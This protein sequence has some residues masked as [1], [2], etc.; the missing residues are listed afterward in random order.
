MSLRVRREGGLSHTSQP[1]LVT[2]KQSHKA[3][4]SKI[5]QPLQFPLVVLLSFTTSSLLSSLL[6]PFFG[7][8]SLRRVTKTPSGWELGALLVWRIFELAVGWYGNYDRWD[9]AA[10]GV[11]S[12][13]PPLYLLGTFYDVNFGELS[14]SLILNILG[15]Y[16]PFGLLRPL[17]SAHRA[18]DELPPGKADVSSD[19][20]IQAITTLL[21]ASIYSVSLYGAYATYLPVNLVSYFPNLTSIVAAHTATPITLLPK[22]LAFG[23]AAKTF[24]FTPATSLDTRSPPFNPVKATFA[25]T[26]W[27]NVWGFSEATRMVLKRTAALA[28]ITGGNTFL[29]TFVALEDVEFLGAVG[30]SAVWFGA[31]G[32]TGLALGIVNAV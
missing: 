1:V 23:I 9:I 20:I 31:A 16:I 2:Q 17:S 18:G 30:Y 4:V 21:G 3:R 15:T 8:E 5:P 26:F 25:E 28:V 24:I 19:Y 14:L 6:V 32:L 22:A 11:L 27:Y 7:N 10:L 13:G 29:Q 12:Q